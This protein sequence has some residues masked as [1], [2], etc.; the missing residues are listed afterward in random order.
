MKKILVSIV[1]LV[2]FSVG[3]AAETFRFALFTDLHIQMINQQ[4]AI[5]LQNAVTDVNA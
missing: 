5:D 4:P 3:Y 2:C 1:L